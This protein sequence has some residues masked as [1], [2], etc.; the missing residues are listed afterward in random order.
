MYLGMR[1][2]LEF[3]RLILTNPYYLSSQIIRK[4]PDFSLT[5]PIYR[6]FIALF[7]ETFGAPS[8][9]RTET[10]YSYDYYW[11][12]RPIP[13][14]LGLRTHI[15]VEFTL[16]R[17]RQMHHIPTHSHLLNKGMY[18]STQESKACQALIAH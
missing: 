10:P 15:K 7:P 3:P 4:N 11:F 12:S 18:P 14:Q 9:T 6:R 16:P 2:R 1:W 8:Q 5:I 17:R 13:Y